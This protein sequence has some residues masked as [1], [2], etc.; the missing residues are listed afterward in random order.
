MYDMI[1]CVLVFRFKWIPADI[2]TA[3]NP[4]FIQQNCSGTTKF[5]KYTFKLMKKKYKNASE[6]ATQNLNRCKKCQK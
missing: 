5:F 3:N 1:R 6:T 4:L 2:S